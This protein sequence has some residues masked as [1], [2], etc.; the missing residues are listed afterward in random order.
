MVNDG[1]DTEPVPYWL[2][3]R[4]AIRN[5]VDSQTEVG[6]NIKQLQQMPHRLMPHRLIDVLLL[7]E[8]SSQYCDQPP[9]GTNASGLFGSAA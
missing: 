4:P 5:P 2:A 3:E 6:I 7:M 8:K 1:Y 9:K